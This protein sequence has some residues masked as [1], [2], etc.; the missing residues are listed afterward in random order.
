MVRWKMSATVCTL[1]IAFVF[2]LALAALAAAQGTPAGTIS[3]YIVDPDRR[4]VPGAR[5]SVESADTGEA[6]HVSSN[7]EGVYSVPALSPGSYNITVA[8]SGFKTLNQ[9]GVV[10]TANQ[11]ARL[12]FVLT[13]GSAT[14]LLGSADVFSITYVGADYR[15]T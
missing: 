2:N 11:K 3:G 4:V 8:A 7:H 14:V 9:N 1:A 12:D 6:H 13:V 15:Q 5:V 10:I